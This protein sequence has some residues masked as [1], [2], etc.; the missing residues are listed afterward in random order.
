MELLRIKL[1]VYN[2]CQVVKLGI[3]SDFHQYPLSSKVRGRGP[4]PTSGSYRADRTSSL[5][6]DFKLGNDIRDHQRLILCC[7]SSSVKCQRVLHLGSR[8][9]CCIVAGTTR[10]GRHGRSRMLEF[11]PKYQNLHSRHDLFLTRSSAI[12]ACYIDLRS[13]W[14]I[15][16]SRITRVPRA[17]IK[18]VKY[19]PF[20]WIFWCILRRTG[21]R[22]CFDGIVFQ[23][24]G[25][26]F[27]PFFGQRGNCYRAV[28]YPANLPKGPV[29]D[30][31]RQN[32]I[33][34]SGHVSRNGKFPGNRSSWGSTRHK[35]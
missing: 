1:I 13:D 33:D 16:E 21:A 4:S 30:R 19:E 3:P 2:V 27:H 17:F 9:C 24:A 25:G 6:G 5:R 10:A 20:Q 14:T 34:F 15:R 26:I 11:R 29:G 28:R 18:K 31:R 23:F 35:D 22:I 7:T 12:T 8:W 32:V